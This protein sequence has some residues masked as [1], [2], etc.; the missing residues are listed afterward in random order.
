[1]ADWFA[2][3][4]N[5]E[6]FGPFFGAE[7]GSGSTLDGAAYL[8]GNGEVTGSLTAVANLSASISGSGDLVSS[9]SYLLPRMGPAFEW[10]SIPSLPV[11]KV[12]KLDLT[13][14]EELAILEFF[15]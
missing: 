13:P 10:T 14:G 4:F 7:E 11:K 2:D 12:P 8:I 5:E 3:W 9:P 6:F 15:M 1:M